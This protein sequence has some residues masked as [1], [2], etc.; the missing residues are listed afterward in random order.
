M[1]SLLGPRRP[2]GKGANVKIGNRVNTS[3]A[4]GL[5]I[6]M[7]LPPLAPVKNYNSIIPTHSLSE[8]STPTNAWNIRR[9]SRVAL[10]GRKRKTRRVSKSKQ[11]KSRRH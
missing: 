8:P 1:S 2:L 10:G 9:E 6:P 3:P 4:P 11:R 7:N 5:S